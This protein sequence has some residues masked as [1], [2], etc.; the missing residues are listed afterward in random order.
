MFLQARFRALLKFDFLAENFTPKTSKKTK[1]RSRTESF[2]RDVCVIEIV[3][4]QK[5]IEN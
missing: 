1:L 4:E 3:N 5:Y 2:E